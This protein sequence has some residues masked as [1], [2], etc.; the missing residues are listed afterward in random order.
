MRRGD[1]FHDYETHRHRLAYTSNGYA[2]KK[3]LHL[4]QDDGHAL[5]LSQQNRACIHVA[6]RVVDLTVMFLL[7]QASA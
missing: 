2:S 1:H 4:G 7:I 5:Y 3:L 6:P